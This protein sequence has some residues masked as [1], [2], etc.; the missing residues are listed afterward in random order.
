MLKE[1]LLEDLKSAM[2]EKDE[3]KKKIYLMRKKIKFKSLRSIETMIVS[4]SLLTNIKIIKL[5]KWI[6][7]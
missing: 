6:L 7:L 4:L 5:L 3:I 1:K 2:K